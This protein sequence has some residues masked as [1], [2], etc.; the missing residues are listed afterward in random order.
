VILPRAFT[1]WFADFVPATGKLFSF[2]YQQ[3]HEVLK[4]HSLPN[5]HCYRRF[6]T[7]H[8]RKMHCSEDVIQCQ[9]GHAKKTLTDGYS[10]AG[11]DL[12]FVRKEIE[13]AGVGFNFDG[14]QEKAA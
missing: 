13:L 6:R 1:S 5:P 3:L 14:V 8:L 7:T 2:S 4:I 12:Q 11:E 9:L 10:H